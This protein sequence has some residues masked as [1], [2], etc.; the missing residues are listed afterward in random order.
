MIYEDLN[1]NSYHNYLFYKKPKKYDTFEN[2]QM[3]I[4]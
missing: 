4:N 2:T 1:V 3:I